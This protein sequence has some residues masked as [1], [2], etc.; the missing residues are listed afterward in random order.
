MATIFSSEMAMAA[1]KTS[2]E[3]TIFPPAMMV[4][5]LMSAMMCLLGGWGYYRAEWAGWHVWGGR[6][7][8]W[9]WGE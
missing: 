8:V 1:S 4:S 3:V 5:T 2:D 7:V 6:G 9:A